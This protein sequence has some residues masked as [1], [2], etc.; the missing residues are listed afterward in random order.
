M[1][2]NFRSHHRDFENEGSERRRREKG[3]RK[4][5]EKG[6]RRKREKG[7]RRGL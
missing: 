3:E 7:E 5:R 4:R 2:E 6:E 1:L